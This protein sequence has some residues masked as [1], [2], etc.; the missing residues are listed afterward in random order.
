VIQIV[1]AVA[2]SQTVYS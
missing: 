1:W 2:L